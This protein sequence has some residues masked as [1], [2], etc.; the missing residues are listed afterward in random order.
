[1]SGFLTITA[2]TRVL[3]V[4][5]KMANTECTVVIAILADSESA[6]EDM[7]SKDT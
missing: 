6:Y 1:M 7:A 5:F 4:R 3:P 2:Q